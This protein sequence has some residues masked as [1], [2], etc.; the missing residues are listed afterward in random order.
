MSTKKYNI[1]AKINAAYILVGLL[2]GEGDFEKTMVLSGRCGQDS[3]CNPSSA[4]SILG[5]F[6]GASKIP[7]KW[8]KGLNITTRKFS[9]TD[10][11][12]DDVVDLNIELMEEVLEEN[13]ATYKDGAWSIEKDTKYTQ[14]EWEQWT[15][16]FDAGILAKNVGDGVVKFEIVTNGPD[17]IKAVTMEMP[18]GFKANGILAYYKFPKSGEYTVK[19]TVESQSG[20]KVQKQRTFVVESLI[21]ATPI[22]SYANPSGGGLAAIFDGYIPYVSDTSKNVQCDTWDGKGEKDFVYAG[23]EFDNTTSI[24]GVDFVEGMHFHDGGWFAEAPVIEVL[25]NGE[26]VVKSTTISREYPKA[27]T[28]AAHGNNF[29]I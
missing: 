7:E 2:W 28:L 25:V 10:Y 24:K 15:D 19:Y 20:V 16:D 27:N 1:D 12:L 3:D 17:P 6:Y 21:S 8:K 26:W 14:V 13:G 29:D 11:T 18:D 9:V 22:C 5:N 4:A 23:L